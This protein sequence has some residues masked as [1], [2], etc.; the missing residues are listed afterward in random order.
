[1][2]NTL[3]L[4]TQPTGNRCMGVQRTCTVPTVPRMPFW[5]QLNSI[6]LLVLVDTLSHIYLEDQFVQLNMTLDLKT[7]RNE[8]FHLVQLLM[9]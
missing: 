6:V 8:Y 1:M 4:L 3:L 5:P 2:L 9:N 7:L